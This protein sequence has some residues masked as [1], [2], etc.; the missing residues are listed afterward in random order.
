MTYHIGY[1]MLL[2]ECPSFLPSLIFM[3]G[4]DRMIVLFTTY[5]YPCKQC[6]STLNLCVRIPLRRGVLD[7]T[8]CDK[9]CQ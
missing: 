6:L 3:R 9:V 4:R 5:N 7:T 2:L 1:D 8:L